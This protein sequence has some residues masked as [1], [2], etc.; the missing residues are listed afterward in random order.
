MWHV[1]SVVHILLV[2]DHCCTIICLF[3]RQPSYF[4]L[5][6]TGFSLWYVCVWACLQLRSCNGRLL[7]L[8]GAAEC[9]GGDI[10]LSKRRSFRSL[11]LFGDYGH[12][13]GIQFLDA[14]ALAAVPKAE[15]VWAIPPVLVRSA[16]T[17]VQSDCQS[18][19]RQGHD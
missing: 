8:A 11:R 15:A 18:L 10:S 12:P 2:R 16:V 7:K 6:V 9:F 13:P 5:T 4:R 14:G 19:G 1:H 3:A 17:A